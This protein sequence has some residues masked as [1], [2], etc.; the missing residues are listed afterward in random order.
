MW[1]IFVASFIRCK[2]TL[3]T[4][5]TIVAVVIKDIEEIDIYNWMLWVG[6]YE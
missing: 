2:I 6:K 1:L 5:K 4:H 3:I